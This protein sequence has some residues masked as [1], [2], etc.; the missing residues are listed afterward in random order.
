MAYVINGGD[1]PTEKFH[2]FVDLCCQAFNI[3]R[4]NRNMFLFLVSG[5]FKWNYLLMSIL[6]MTSSGICS[7]TPESIAYMHNALLP[8][9]SNPEAASHFT[10]LI[11]ESLKTKFTQFNFFLHN[12]AQNL[13]QLKFT[14]D[15]QSDT[16]LSFVPKM[17]R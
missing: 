6:Q 4:N 16:T 17:Y 3:I 5:G 2:Q 1:R 13:A 11:E 8:K 15:N 12:L 10:R 14:T 9:A 7:I